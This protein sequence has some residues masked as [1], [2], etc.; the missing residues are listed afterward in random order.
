MNRKEFVQHT[1]ANTISTYLH[2]YCNP[3]TIADAQEK[4]LRD[5]EKLAD[6]V[7]GVITQKT[8]VV[9]RPALP[10]RT[11]PSLAKRRKAIPRTI[12]VAQEPPPPPKETRDESDNETIEEMIG[13][14]TGNR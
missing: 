6:Q 5:A 14:L 13:R 1:V 11:S 4:C 8:E 2:R 10:E 9:E 12:D 3:W 7:Y